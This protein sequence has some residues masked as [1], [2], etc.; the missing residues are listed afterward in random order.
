MPTLRSGGAV[1]LGDVYAFISSLYYRGKR[2]YG[3]AFGRRPGDGPS[4]LVVTP[5]RG[6]VSDEEPVTL[7]DL[8][9]LAAG[10]VDPADPDYLQPLLSTARTLRREL[11]PRDGVVLL[12]S[13]AS[14]KYLEPLL[15]VF[16]ERLLFPRAFVGRGDMSRGGLL[17][18]RVEAGEELEYVPAAA[19]QRTG[20]RPPKLDG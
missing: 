5:S 11:D 9:E 19:A 6:L 14:D 8:R 10:D 12:G 20:T 18:R 15:E 1:P 7:E 3:R 17:L 16:G 4:T 2:S 13:I